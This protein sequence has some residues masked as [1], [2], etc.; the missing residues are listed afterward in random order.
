MA[1][2]IL[3]IISVVLLWGIFIFTVVQTPYPDTL[4]QAKTSQ[5]IF[6][7]APLLL[8][9]FLTI[10]LFLKNFPSSCSLSL[11][12]ISLLILKALDSLNLVTASLIVITVGLLVSYFR[13][14]KRKS[15]STGSGLKNLTNRSKIP[16]LTHMRKH[17]TS[18]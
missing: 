4:T 16:K 15:P 9:L 6:F 8:A 7:F 12:L 18:S 10:N 13:K 1:K 5:L 2:F 3:K 17:N 14:I 11:G